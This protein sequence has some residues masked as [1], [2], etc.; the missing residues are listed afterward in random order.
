MSLS[1]S[2]AVTLIKHCAFTAEAFTRSPMRERVGDNNSN[3]EVSPYYVQGFFKREFFNAIQA[4]GGMA[5]EW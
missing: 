3:I 1:I 4:A 5:G 2:Q